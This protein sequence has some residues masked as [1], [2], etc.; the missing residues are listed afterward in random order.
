MIPANSF[1]CVIEP[2][3][4]FESCLAIKNFRSLFSMR[5][6]IRFYD[7]TL[8]G[9]V[10]SLQAPKVF[11]LAD[12]SP[13]GTEPS[14]SPLSERSIRAAGALIR[15]SKSNASTTILPAFRQVAS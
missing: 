9:V 12:R 14:I 8:C 6:L 1:V 5:Y 4:S 10:R 15:V 2:V 13:S 3:N 7:L 11:K